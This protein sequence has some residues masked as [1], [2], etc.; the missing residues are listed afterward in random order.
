MKAIQKVRTLVGL[1]LAC[2]CAQGA[3]A[4]NDVV[5]EAWVMET[6]FESRAIEPALRSRLVVNE[7]VYI[8]KG[9]FETDVRQKAWEAENVDFLSVPKLTVKLGESTGFN[10]T[11]IQ[12]ASQERPTTAPIRADEEGTFYRFKLATNGEPVQLQ[13]RFVWQSKQG[14][15]KGAVVEKVAEYEGSFTFKDG[16]VAIVKL[17][18]VVR[19]RFRRKRFLFIP[20]GKKKIVYQEDLFV[21]VGVSK[22]GTKHRGGLAQ[23]LEARVEAFGGRLALR[24]N[25]PQL[26]GSWTYREDQFGGDIKTQNISL[27]QFD[28]FIKDYIGSPVEGGKTPEGDVQWVIPAKTMG[29]SIWYS[30]LDEGVQITVLRPLNLP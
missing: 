14:D 30:K 11:N 5:I 7:P 6:G 28:S 22:V 3:T 8:S 16:D 13:F 23:F 21:A 12:T 10:I 2:V 4:G 24:P 9:Q 20:L 15:K 29:V 27:Q 26:H 18:P 17:N 19:E 25:A 1:F